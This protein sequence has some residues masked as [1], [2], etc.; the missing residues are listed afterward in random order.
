MDINIITHAWT[1]LRT[2]SGD[3]NMLFKSAPK[4]PRHQLA[5]VAQAWHWAKLKRNADLVIGRSPVTIF[6]L[7][8]SCS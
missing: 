3:L 8:K 4:H 5:E 6:E 7:Y 1:L 2:H